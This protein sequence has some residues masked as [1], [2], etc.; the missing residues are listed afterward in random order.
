[1]KQQTNTFRH[2]ANPAFQQSFVFHVPTELRLLQDTTVNVSVFDHDRFRSDFLIGQVVLGCLATEVS[3]YG[4]WQE[5]LE[6]SGFMI[7][8]W[9]YLIDRGDWRCCVYVISSIISY[10]L[11]GHYSCENAHYAIIAPLLSR[12]K[13]F[14]VYVIYTW[15]DLVGDKVCSMYKWPCMYK[16]NMYFFNFLSS[17]L[18]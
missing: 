4:H 18:N 14:V 3:Q 5:M 16:M 1:M 10:S 11:I 7:S 12:L 17:L 6:N 8:K 15:Q 2:E 13:R 9:H